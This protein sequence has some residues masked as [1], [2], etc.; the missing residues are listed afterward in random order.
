V[1]IEVA[2]RIKKI[3]LY[4]FSRIDELKKTV[5]NRKLIDLGMGNPDLPTPSHIVEKLKESL[6][7]PS[8]YR[9]PPA[10][11][12][13]ELRKAIAQW[14]KQR[15][16]V[17]LDPEKEILPLIGSKEGIV[18]TYLTFLNSGDIAIVP[19]PAYPVHFNGVILAGGIPYSLPIR[20][21]NNFLPDFSSIPERILRKAKIIFIC[22]PNNPTTAVANREF[23]KEAVAFA[24]KYNLILA[25]DC[26]C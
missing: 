14:Y 22:Y 10:K 20:K 2:E 15:Y 9:Y 8:A 16:N 24:Q 12:E 21:E 5:N 19:T 17:H 7:L 3:P 26:L 11:G 1:N 13:E 18:I 23:F 25:H 6:M 4:L